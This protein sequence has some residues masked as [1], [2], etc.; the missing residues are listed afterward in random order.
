MSDLIR[1]PY[2]VLG[3]EFRPMIAHVDGRYICGKCGHTTRLG[4]AVYECQCERC[5]KYRMPMVG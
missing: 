5:L 2:C 1:C 3:F 4:D